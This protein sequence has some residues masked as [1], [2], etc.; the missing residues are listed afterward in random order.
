MGIRG[1]G[2]KPFSHRDIM[3]PS[4]GKAPFDRAGWIF[5]LNYDGYRAIVG[6][7]KGK[8]EDAFPP[9]QRLPTVL[10]RDRGLPRDAARHGVG[11]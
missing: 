6:K 1:P 7:H 2:A 10:S 11:R 8:Y 5:E 3:A 9:R 4:I